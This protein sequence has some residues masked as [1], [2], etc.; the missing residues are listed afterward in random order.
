[1]LPNNLELIILV[2]VTLILVVVTLIPV[3]VTPELSKFSGVI[4]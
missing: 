1:V 4:P 2:V 3:V